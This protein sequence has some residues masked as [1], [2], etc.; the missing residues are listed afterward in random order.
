MMT[1]VIVMIGTMMKS[2]PVITRLPFL[3]LQLCYNKD[4]NIL[5]TMEVIIDENY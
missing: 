4:R 5:Y 1:A 3:T 2:V